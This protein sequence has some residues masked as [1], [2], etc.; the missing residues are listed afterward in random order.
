M[1]HDFDSMSV[2][3]RLDE[4]NINYT[5]SNGMNNDWPNNINDSIQFLFQSTFQLQK[6]IVDIKINNK[7]KV[8]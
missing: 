2:L 3:L 4:Y 7:S 8:K 6:P 5:D 1:I